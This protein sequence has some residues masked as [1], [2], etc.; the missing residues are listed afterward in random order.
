MRLA[1][2]RGSLS[3]RPLKTCRYSHRPLS[4]TRYPH[5]SSA[6]AVARAVPVLYSDAASTFSPRGLGP[7]PVLILPLSYTKSRVLERARPYYNHEYPLE[8]LAIAAGP[9]PLFKRPSHS[10]GIVFLFQTHTRHAL[11]CETLGR[12]H[13]LLLRSTLTQLRLHIL[14][15]A[16]PCTAVYHS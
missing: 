9:G 10:T 5:S 6:V 8:K 11:A 1:S 14:S 15:S 3:D 7:P 13:T 2:I 12:S 16:R 4:G